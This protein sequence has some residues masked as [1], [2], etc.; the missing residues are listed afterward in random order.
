MNQVEFYMYETRKDWV[1]SFA[2]GNF[3]LHFEESF[4]QLASITYRY[5]LNLYLHFI[6][7]TKI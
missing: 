3:Y 2:K 5:K 7:K 1:Y 6:I 4:I